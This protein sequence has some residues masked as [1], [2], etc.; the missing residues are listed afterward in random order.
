MGKGSFEEQVLDEVVFQPHETVERLPL[1][2]GPIAEPDDTLPVWLGVVAELQAIGLDVLEVQSVLAM[3]RQ[4]HVL[5]S[6]D[7]IKAEHAL[8]D[9]RYR[10]VCES[11]EYQT[12]KNA[13]TR[14]A[15]LAR[16]TSKE[17]AAVRQASAK[18]A[19]TRLALDL[20]LDDARTVQM[21][22]EALGK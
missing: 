12:G 8:Q 10:L 5:A 6:L 1:G 14:E 2:D 17:V 21:L 3:T 11:Q 9:A 13:E 19:Q 18:V 4:G 16:L 20:A 22:V 7:L 15:I